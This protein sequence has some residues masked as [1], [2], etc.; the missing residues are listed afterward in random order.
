MQTIAVLGTGGWGTALAVH[1]ARTGHD[2]HLWGRDASLVARMRQTRENAVYLPGI[3]LPP[4]LTPCTALDDTLAG[5]SML[6]VAVPSHGLRATLAQ[7]V[8][9]LPPSIPIV[10][11]VKGLEQD[12]RLRM[13]EV[14]AHEVQHAAA[15]ARSEERRV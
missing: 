14:I 11:T 2:V 4:R 10:S 15:G 3:A 7:A 6:V 8:P 13:S 1:L 12:T 9:H 5:A